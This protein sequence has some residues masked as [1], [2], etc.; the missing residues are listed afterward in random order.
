MFAKIGFLIFLFS[1]GI[2]ISTSNLLISPKEKSLAKKFKVQRQHNS[3]TDVE[4]R[5]AYMNLLIA[6][7]TRFLMAVGL[8]L[9]VISYFFDF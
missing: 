2:A 3:A 4:T 6:N 7:V 8:L 5:Y 1:L 9:V